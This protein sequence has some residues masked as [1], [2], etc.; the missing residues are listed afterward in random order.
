SLDVCSSD[1]HGTGAKPNL[2]AYLR[3]KSGS[4]SDLAKKLLSCATIWHSSCAR[5]LTNCCGLLYSISR[6][7]C[8]ANSQLELLP[9]VTQTDWPE[10]SCQPLIA[11][12][13]SAMT[14]V[15]D[16]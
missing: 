7:P 10:I 14:T 3:A 8:S 4:L 11:V 9:T 5:P 1:L 6:A 15:S 13:R 2:T 12:G 16:S